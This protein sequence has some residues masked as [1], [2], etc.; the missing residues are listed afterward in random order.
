MDGISATNEIR[1]LADPLKARTPIIALTANAMKGDEE[2]YLAA[3]M[4]GYLT[5][6]IDNRQLE[7]ILSHWL[8]GE[9]L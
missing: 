2:E 3:G 8:K 7:A 4:N 9:T 1:Q 6:P 5:K